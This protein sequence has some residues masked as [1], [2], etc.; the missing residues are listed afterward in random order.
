VHSDLVS[1][2]CTVGISVEADIITI[3]NTNDSGPGSLRQALVDANDGDTINFAVT[4][5]IGLTSGELLVDKSITISGPGAKNL[6]IGGNGKSCVFYVASGETV[7][8][9]A[10]TII[11]GHTTDNGGGIHNDH[12]T[13]ILNDCA[14]TDNL[15]DNVGGAIY[16]NGEQN[17][18]ALVLID[19][20]SFSDNLANYNGGAIFNDREVG[21]NASV[22]LNNSSLSRN[23]ASFDGGAIF[24]DGS[25]SGTAYL[26]I[27]LTTLSGNS[28]NVN[29]GS[30]ANDCS[31]VGNATLQIVNSTVN[32]NAANSGAGHLQQW[33]TV[34]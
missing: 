31:V 13:L 1:L 24:N 32:G 9:S 20:T 30:V 23:A 12:A 16:N 34:R 21:G 33:A 3:T 7:T 6:A 26:Q 15:A 5:T 10:L 11:S 29:G 28:A 17:G 2:V 27:A 18:S 25:F 14:L 19:N 4:G 22:G 8:I